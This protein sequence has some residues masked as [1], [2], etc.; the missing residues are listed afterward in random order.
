V[1]DDPV[2]VIEMPEFQ[3]GVAVAYCDPPGPLE[4]AP[5]PTFFAVSPTPADWPAARVE[6][7]FREYNAH[8]VHD[9]AVHEGIPGHALQLAHARRF[10][11][12]TR[13]RAALWSGPFV[14]GWAVYAERLMVEQGYR[15]DALRMQ[16]LKMQLRMILNAILDARVHAHG[17]TEEEAMR[18]LLERGHQ[19]DG[20][21]AGKWR[22]A[23]L[24]STQLST[25]FVGYIEVSDLAADLAAAHPGLAPREL[26]G[27]MLAHGSPP[28]RHLRSLLGL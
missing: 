18:L 5:L 6:S 19:E 20:E 11:A 27:R 26:H 10:Q 14:E 25:Y 12:P 8:L 23:L 17:M 4:T 24:S 28:P 2:V 3:R 22:R 21:A 7:F 1:Y 13:L 9:L 16:H 15:D